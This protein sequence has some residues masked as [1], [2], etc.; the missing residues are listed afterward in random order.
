MALAG[1]EYTDLTDEEILEREAKLKEIADKEREEA[2][3]RY[4]KM[5][6]FRFKGGML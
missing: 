6:N 1:Y 4:V 2:R 3:K 5:N